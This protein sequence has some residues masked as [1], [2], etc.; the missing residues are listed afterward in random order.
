M[1]RSTTVILAAAAVVSFCGLYA[2]AEPSETLPNGRGIG[3][4]EHQPQGDANGGGSRAAKPGSGNG[5]SYHN[6]PILTS[7]SHVYYIWYGNWRS[8]S[9]QEILPALASGLSGSPYFNINTTY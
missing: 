9:A 3:T 6:G 2:V 5:I 1:K 7:G 8:N 4:R